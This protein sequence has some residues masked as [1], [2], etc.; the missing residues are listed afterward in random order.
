[1]PY[2]STNQNLFLLLS[3]LFLF[4]FIIWISRNY[5]LNFLT[6]QISFTTS[7]PIPHQLFTFHAYIWLHVWD[8][9]QVLRC[10]IW[11]CTKKTWRITWCGTF[12]ASNNT[13]VHLSS[14]ARIC[15]LGLK[16]PYFQMVPV[17][18]V[19]CDTTMV[20]DS[21]LELWPDI[22]SREHHFPKAQIAVLDDTKIQYTC[23]K[24][25]FLWLFWF[26]LCSILDQVGFVGIGTCALYVLL[27]DAF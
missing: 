10:S 11:G 3:L 18:D 24:R 13:G 26:G 22:C 4:S 15:L 6:Q 14:T 20:F 7:H 9:G 27:W 8:H 21:N 19:A 5:N 23:M 17:V 1:M 25:S 12:N 2:Q 16:A